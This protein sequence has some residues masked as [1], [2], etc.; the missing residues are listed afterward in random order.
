L[1]DEGEEA[2]RDPAFLDSL[3]PSASTVLIGEGQRVSVN[4]RVVR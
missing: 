2:W 1:P 3:M 4:P